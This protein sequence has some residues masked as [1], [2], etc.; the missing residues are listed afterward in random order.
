MHKILTLLSLLSWSSSLLATSYY[1]K[2]VYGLDNRQEPYQSSNSAIHRYA[3]ATAAMVPADIL[4]YIPELKSYIF[5]TS[6][7]AEDIN[8]CSD[9]RF[10]DQTHIAICSGFLV[11]KDILVTAG[12]CIETADDCKNFKW[13]FD[14]TN[15]SQLLNRDNVYGCEKVISRL[16][17]ENNF[18]LRDYAIIKLDREVEDRTPLKFRTKGRVR[19][20]T[21][22]IL[23]GH[24]T[25]LPLKYDANATVARKWNKYEVQNLKTRFFTFFKRNSYFT[26]RLDAFA[27]NSGSPV[28]NANTGKVEGILVAG[29]NDYIYDGNNE[30]VR[31]ERFTDSD[32]EAQE[33]VFKITQIPELK[34][35]D[36]DL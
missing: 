17:K 35:I 4:R 10:G 13:V 25:G 30:C 9:E 6:T 7:L 11:G 23:I 29:S 31:V 8:L 18:V 3:S 19:K 34:D 26:A 24:P 5:P 15:E 27:G 14:Y 21:P 20:G 16:R 33:I 28:I 32:R 12:H 36:L 22:L 2:G 1:N